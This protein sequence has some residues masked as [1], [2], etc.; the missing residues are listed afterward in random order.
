MPFDQE[1]PIIRGAHG[2]YNSDFRSRR[3]A[4]GTKRF[5]APVVS[6]LVLSLVFAQRTHSGSELT[7]T[8][9]LSLPSHVILGERAEPLIAKGGRFGFVASVADGALLAFSLNNGTVL[10]SFVAGKTAGLPSQVET[11]SLRLIALPCLNDPDQGHAATVSIID[12]TDPNELSLRSLLVLHQHF[13]SHRQLALS[14]LE[15]ADTAL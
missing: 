2:P 1:N 3:S 8:S 9:R 6:L 14:L 15:M 11:E 12:A 13:I 7:D 5:V 10:S 4:V